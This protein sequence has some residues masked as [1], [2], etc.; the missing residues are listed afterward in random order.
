MPKTYDIRRIVSSAAGGG[1]GGFEIVGLKDI[2]GD[3]LNPST[4]ETQAS[5]LLF[6]KSFES[7]TQQLIDQ[8]KITNKYLQKI[9]NPE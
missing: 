6:M 3:Q 8:Q 5:I 4:E 9:Y 2:A 1:G 7:L